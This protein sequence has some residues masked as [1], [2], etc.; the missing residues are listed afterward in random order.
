[1]E[2]VG[3][4]SAKVKGI[5]RSEHRR[6]TLQ[7]RLRR[8]EGE[9]GRGGEHGGGERSEGLWMRERSVCEGN[10][11]KGSG[12]EGSGKVSDSAARRVRRA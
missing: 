8:G 10:K 7:L 3:P 2:R 1:M 6:E 9:G 12:C 11:C 4:E 5:G